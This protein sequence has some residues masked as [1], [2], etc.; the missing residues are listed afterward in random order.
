MPFHQ[1]LCGCLSDT[2]QCFDTVCCCCCQM[3]RQCSAI[4]A[5]PDRHD[6]GMCLLALCLG[7]FFP[8]CLRCKISDKF[9]LEEHCCTSCLSGLCCASCSVCQTGREL[10]FR[11]LNPGGFCCKPADA[12]SMD[13]SRLRSSMP[14]S[15]AKAT[16]TTGGQS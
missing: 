13:I 10:N 15:T 9:M 8:V 14:Q 6:C 16:Y 11:G 5:K 7:E 1:S 3:S 4:D 12:K 2:S